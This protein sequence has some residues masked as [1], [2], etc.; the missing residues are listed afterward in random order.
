MHFVNGKYSQINLN[1][2]RKILDFF[3]KTTGNYVYVNS[4][5]FPE[6]F[7]DRY[8]EILDVPIDMLRSVGELCDK[9]DFD[10]EKLKLVVPELQNSK[11]LE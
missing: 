8:A 5:L 3:D 4:Y 2:K 6:K 11:I 10:K 1:V 7:F 9:P